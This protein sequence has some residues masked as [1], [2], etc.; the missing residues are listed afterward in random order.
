MLLLVSIMSSDRKQYSTLSERKKK[1]TFRL[2]VKSKY[3]SF[4]QK[5]FQETSGKQPKNFQAI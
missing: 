1:E 4:E 2:D 3:R 5:K